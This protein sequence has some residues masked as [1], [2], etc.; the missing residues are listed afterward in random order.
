MFSHS[1]PVVS[2]GERTPAASVAS[3]LTKQAD[4]T[5]LLTEPMT[6]SGHICLMWVSV[7]VDTAWWIRGRIIT[8]RQNDTNHTH[9]RSFIN[10]Y[11]NRQSDKDYKENKHRED[12]YL[13]F[14]VDTLSPQTVLQLV[15]HRGLI[16][17]CLRQSW[18][19]A[20]EGSSTN[21]SCSA[22]ESIGENLMTACPAR[23]FL[24]E[25]VFVCGLLASQLAANLIGSFTDAL[26]RKKSMKQRD[27]LSLD[28]QGHLMMLKIMR[29]CR[30]G[31]HSCDGG[32][33]EAAGW[34]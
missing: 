21:G 6:A 5:P 33:D 17:S 27:D 18:F 14:K 24:Q 28:Y 7:P 12:W 30:P 4:L 13:I 1:F 25:K 34:G 8:S 22:D 2:C 9:Q 11:K 19:V 29:I 3:R 15:P 20:D 23:C 26:N 10:I 31:E 16:L 32:A